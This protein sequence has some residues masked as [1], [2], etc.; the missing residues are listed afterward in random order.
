MAV[1]LDGLGHTVGLARVV[2]VARQPARQRGVHHAPLVQPEHVDAAVLF[3]STEHVIYYIAFIFFAY[4]G[5]RL[6]VKVTAVHE[7]LFSIDGLNQKVILGFFCQWQ[8]S[9]RKLAMLHGRAWNNKLRE[10]APVC[11]LSPQVVF[12]EIGHRSQNKTR[13]I[14]LKKASS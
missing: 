9:V 13:S 7:V 11:D 10:V 5:E 12:V 6:I 2:D 4:L 14:L 3:M 8:P 1:H